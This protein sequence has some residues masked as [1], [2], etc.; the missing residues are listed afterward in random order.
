MSKFEVVTRIINA[1]ND[2]VD[3]F[4]DSEF[5]T[6]AEAN[7]QVEKNYANDLG[8]TFTY[9]GHENCSTVYVVICQ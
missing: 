3:S 8:Q 6:E 9:G 4:S 1:N 5:D 7:A 2:C